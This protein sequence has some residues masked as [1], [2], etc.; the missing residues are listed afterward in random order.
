M[1]VYFYNRKKQI[2]PRGRNN[3]NKSDVIGG[4]VMMEGTINTN[5]KNI[6]FLTGVIE[7]LIEI[8]NNQQREITKLKGK[9]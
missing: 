8:T 6:S 7:E 3:K 1:S 4:I 9:R 5:G 2:S